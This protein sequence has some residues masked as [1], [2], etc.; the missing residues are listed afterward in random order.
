[1]VMIRGL[2]RDPNARSLGRVAR[3]RAVPIRVSLCLLRICRHDLL[4]LDC[5]GLPRIHVTR[6]PRHRL[7][8]GCAHA[9]PWLSRYGPS[10]PSAA[11]SKPFQSS[12]SGAFKTFG[13]YQGMV[14]GLLPVLTDSFAALSTTNLRRSYLDN[15]ETTQTLSSGKNERSPLTRDHGPSS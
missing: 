10:Y 4:R 14:V 9:G 7:L 5:L 15:H 6:A 3:L 2:L 12:G 13:K 8:L 1:M 11:Q